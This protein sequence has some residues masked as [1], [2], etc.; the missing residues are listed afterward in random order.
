MV[1][2]V[3]F[4]ELKEWYYR[5]TIFIMP[6][7]RLSDGATDGLPTVVIESLACGTPV[8]GTTTAAI[9]EV[10]LHGKTG[11]LVPPNEPSAMADQILTLLSQEGLRSSLAHEGRRLIE[12]NFNV[13]RNSETLARLI[14][15]PSRIPQGFALNELSPELS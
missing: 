4:A 1:G 10:I 5:A 14:L 15:E 12:K 7:V 13:L 3:A 8:I 2:D 9:P 11:L 6:S